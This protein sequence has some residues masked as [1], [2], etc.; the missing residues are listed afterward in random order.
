MKISVKL[1]IILLSVS[2]CITASLSFVFFKQSEKIIINK[3]FE[4]CNNLAL[5]LST[6]AREELLLNSTYEGSLGVIR[7]L[8]S[9]KNPSLLSAYVFNKYGVYVVD[10]EDK[11]KGRKL[12]EKELQYYKD[13]KQAN[14]SYIQNEVKD[15]IRFE[16][17]VYLDGKDQ[18]SLRLGFVVF[19]Y[20]RELLYESISRFKE[21][22]YILSFALFVAIIIISWVVSRFFTKNISLLTEGAKIVGEGNLDEEI[23]IR[24]RDEIG[25]LARNF[26]LMTKRLQIADKQKKALL[27]SY[28]RFVPIEF[29]DYLDRESVVDIVLG[30]QIE[31]DMSILFSDIRSF[32]TISEKMTADE[33]FKFINSYLEAMEPQVQKNNGFVDKYIG[34]AIMALFKDSNNAIDAAIN[35]LD[36]LYHFNQRREQRGE[37]TIKIGIGIH[38][39]K[40][41]LGVVGSSLRVQGT[42][43]S[44]AVNL[45]SRLEGLTKMYGAAL[46]VSEDSLKFLQNKDKYQYR[47]ID[48]VVVKGRENPVDVYEI[49][50]GNS[51]RIIDLKLSTIGDFVSGLLLSRE[52]N[53]EDAVQL[54]TQVLEKDPMD[55]AAK[56]HLERCQYYAKHGVPPDWEGTA[57][58]TEK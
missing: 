37:I 12:A 4:V 21:Y 55:K 48:K 17:P 27:E 44:D 53:F 45:A 36:E 8:R 20:D 19:E 52:R 56:L 31:L 57:V 58:M 35:M 39:G 32:T 41:I 50:N 15:I 28:S 7:K 25:E 47:M 11:R 42:V 9:S 22:I 5:N 13:I 33:T 6:V 34:D 2:F 26:N 51:Q 49:L 1:T 16:F 54:F 30:D 40:L 14:I 10:M 29:L 3:T 43:I 46:L 24:S 18:T 38:T 23:R